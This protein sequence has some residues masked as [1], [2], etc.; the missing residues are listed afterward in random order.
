MIDVP[1]NE[2]NP[3]KN[4]T[5]KNDTEIEISCSCGSTL[6]PTYTFFIK[7]AGCQVHSHGPCAG[8]PTPDLVP[9][10]PWICDK[11]VLEQTMQR[12]ELSQLTSQ[13]S[14]EEMTK[15]TLKLLVLNFVTEFAYDDIPMQGCRR[16]LLSKWSSD[17][18]SEGN[19][20][21]CKIYGNLW[22]MPTKIIS[23][24]L[25]NTFLSPLN[26]QRAVLQ[27]SVS[28]YTN[29]FDFCRPSSPNQSL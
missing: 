16:F 23:S 15:L 14:S 2:K 13:K 4:E 27:V 8:F 19:A 12:Q 25:R 17:A 29:F 28:L 3:T 10:T 1:V 7:C 20:A 22:A 6:L 9:Q 26:N 18:F 21:A 11:C 5:E 24:E